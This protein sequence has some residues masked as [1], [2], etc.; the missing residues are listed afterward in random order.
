MADKVHKYRC[1]DKCRNQG[2]KPERTRST[3]TSYSASAHI[4]NFW[5]KFNVWGSSQPVTPPTSFST[6]R[7]NRVPASEH[8][9]ASAR[10]LS[11]PTC[12]ANYY[13]IDSTGP[14]F[15]HPRTRPTR[16]SAIA[17]PPP[18]WPPARARTR[19]YKD[20]AGAPGWRRM[21]KRGVPNGLC[22]PFQFYAISGPA[23]HSSPLIRRPR[24]F[25]FY[26]SR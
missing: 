18:S 5:G 14:D 21:G 6:I 7:W 17:M 2:D 23:S 19:I 15:S 13:A 1:R 16:S 11:S 12:S 3:E 4:D 22:K 25:R 9:T 8:V 26:A 24:K 10:R 20:L